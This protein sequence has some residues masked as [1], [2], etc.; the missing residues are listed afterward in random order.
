MKLFNKKITLDDAYKAINTYI[1]SGN[2]ENNIIL[3]RSKNSKKKGLVLKG[4]FISCAIS[5]LPKMLV[6]CAK[7]DKNFAKAMIT[8]SEAI[9]INEPDMMEFSNKLTGKTSRDSDLREIESELK[10]KFPKHDIVSIDVSKL[11]NMDP[12]EFNKIIDKI[13][14]SSQNGDNR[15]EQ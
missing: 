14:K 3:L 11:Q 4:S 8:A 7:G 10:D 12:E 2:E 13:Y 6:E 5:A 1:A 15:S 9:K